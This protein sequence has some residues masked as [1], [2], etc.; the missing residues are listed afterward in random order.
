VTAASK[1][2]KRLKRPS[3]R[4]LLA[5]LALTVGM[6]ACSGSG[7]GGAGTS[8]TAPPPGGVSSSPSTGAGRSPGTGSGS[9]SA[10][11]TTG[12]RATSPSS[13]LPHPDHVV[14]V[15][16]ENRSYDDII[17]NPRAPYING[18]A[19]GGALFTRS[20]AVAH[21]SQPNYLALFSGSIQG[22]HDDSCP[23]T[24]DGPNLGRSLV[25]AGRSFAGYAEGLPS[26]GSQ[27]CEDGAYVRKHAPWVN[28]PSVPASANLP[29]SAFPGDLPALPD[30][31][32]VIP[33]LDHDMHDGSI[34]DGDRWLRDHLGAYVSWAAAHNSLLLLTWDEDDRSESN[35]VV[36]VVT[37]AHV[38]PGRYVEPIDHYRLFSTLEA[39]EGVR[40]TGV[41]PAANPPITS[42]WT[43]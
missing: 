14:V 27:V 36:T 26:P 15:V 2:P 42:I 16:M 4:G 28:F 22:L 25:E 5:V 43:H 10:G 40:S 3:G 18:L 32:F 29:F 39:L 6:S 35:R 17:G 37:G 31:S 24:F 30:L 38:R 23:H 9:T 34:G 1:R 12:T 19:A 13:A 33:D 20:Y 21:P 11:P 8:S 41:P 7:T